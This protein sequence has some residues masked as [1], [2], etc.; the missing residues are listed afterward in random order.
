MVNEII[1]QLAV[2]FATLVGRADDERG[3]DLVEYAVLVGAIGIVAFGVLITL[4]APAFQTMHDKIA[5]CVSF[6]AGC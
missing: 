2:R 4:G 5:S 1:L 6:S 3:Q